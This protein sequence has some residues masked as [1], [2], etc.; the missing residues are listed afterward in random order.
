MG[1]PNA[2]ACQKNMIQD[3]GVQG[4]MPELASKLFEPFYFLE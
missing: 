3:V 2:E 4:G 1:H